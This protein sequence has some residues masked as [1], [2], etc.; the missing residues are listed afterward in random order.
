MQQRSRTRSTGSPF[1]TALP[2]PHT[3]LPP[4]SAGQ[5]IDQCLNIAAAGC[6]S[7][8]GMSS[9]QGR[10]NLIT[11]ILVRKLAAIGEQHD[12]DVSL[13]H[14]PDIAGGV[15]EAARL[16]DDVDAIEVHVLPRHRLPELWTDLEPLTLDHLERLAQLRVAHL[17]VEAGGD[18]DREIAR[19]REHLPGAGK[20]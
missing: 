15:V 9:R 19:G 13:R 5:S 7:T 8:H 11:R 2:L 20:V 3:S 6:G 16:V 18:E 12:A 1:S 4:V 14:Q 17:A 10:K